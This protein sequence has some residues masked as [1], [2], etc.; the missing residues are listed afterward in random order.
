[1]EGMGNTKKDIVRTIRKKQH[2]IQKKP[3]FRGK[4]IRNQ[5]ILPNNI[6][7]FLSYL[8]LLAIPTTTSSFYFFFYYA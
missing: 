8:C 6:G 7:L 2:R 3:H 5:S 4:T 1:M